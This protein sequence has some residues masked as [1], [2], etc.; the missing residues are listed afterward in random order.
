MRP[1]TPTLDD[2]ATVAAFLA[3]AVKERLMLNARTAR[4]A[5]DAYA[6]LCKLTPAKS[7]E[8]LCKMLGEEPEA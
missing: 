7:A 8:L 4:E 6:R 1:P 5:W 2:H 3:M